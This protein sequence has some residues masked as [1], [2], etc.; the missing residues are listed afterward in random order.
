MR[1]GGGHRE[2]SD[3]EYYTLN[4]Q[5]C[6]ADCHTI[7]TSYQTSI[8]CQ[9][10]SERSLL[11]TVKRVS[12]SG[13]FVVAV[14]ILI[15]AYLDFSACSVGIIRPLGR[16]GWPKANTKNEAHNRDCA[17]GISCSVCASLGL[18][19]GLDLLYVVLV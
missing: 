1:S 11:L 13:S 7:S 10:W 6:T 12:V 15:S 9:K 3:C 2:T 16:L 19:L 4:Q 17:R 18:G 8:A 14:E 5:I